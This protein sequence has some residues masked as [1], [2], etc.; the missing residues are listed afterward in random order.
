MFCALFC[1]FVNAQEASKNWCILSNICVAVTVR[2]REVW[3]VGRQAP[4]WAALQ[5]LP[6]AGGKSIS[7]GAGGTTRTRHT[8]MPS[9]LYDKNLVM[10]SHFIYRRGDRQQTCS[11]LSVLSYYA[12][13]LEW[14][15]MSC[16]HRCALLQDVGGGSCARDGSRLRQPQRI[17]RGTL[18][19]LRHNR[20]RD[21]CEYKRPQPGSDQDERGSCRAAFD[22][23]RRR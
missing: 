4:A 6:A 15:R 21:A 13:L 8:L 16:A 20:Q 3:Q 18:G 5:T 10:Y 1:V 22:A 12:V 2:F 23:R 11:M 19:K 14:K 9:F 7:I 17:T